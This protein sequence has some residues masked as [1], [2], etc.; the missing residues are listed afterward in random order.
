[1]DDWTESED[2]DPCEWV[3]Y[4]TVAISGD[5]LLVMKTSKNGRAFYLHSKLNRRSEIFEVS[6]EFL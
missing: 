5:S 4:K 2:I 3:S 1:V 6:K